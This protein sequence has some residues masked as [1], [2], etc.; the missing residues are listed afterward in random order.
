M[1]V[2]C[3]A[4]VPDPVRYVRREQTPLISAPVFLRHVDEP[5]D[6][7]LRPVPVP[8]V[9][10]RRVV[11]VKVAVRVL[12]NH[13]PS[14]F[15]RVLTLASLASLGEG[16]APVRLPRLTGAGRQTQGLDEVRFDPPA[17]VSVHLRPRGF[18]ESLFAPLLARE[19]RW[20]RAD[21]FVVE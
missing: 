7:I 13:L 15:L 9:F 20:A 14:E 18:F 8:R 10:P 6:L 12:T 4:L 21:A 11:P 19:V 16:P 17:K 5:I 2:H 1:P 3:A